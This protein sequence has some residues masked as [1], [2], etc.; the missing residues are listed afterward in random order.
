MSLF[1]DSILPVV[2]VIIL[3]TIGLIFIFRFIPATKKETKVIPE[4]PAE[5]RTLENMWK[6]FNMQIVKLHELGKY[7]E[8]ALLA[9]EA[10]KMAKESLNP[11]HPQIPIL[12]NNVAALYK[13]QGKISEAESLYKQ[14][15]AIWAK[16]SGRE[17]SE[18]AFSLNNLAELYFSTGKYKEAEP[19][20]KQ[21][22]NMFEKLLGK[23]DISVAT[24]LDNIADLYKKTGRS[25]KAVILEERARLIRE[26]IKKKPK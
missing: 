7:A 23:N 16:I 24:V 3:V 12:M 22:L 10:L 2:I 4:L 17:N 13:T 8:A 11:D 14:A 1:F 25:D 18:F 6:S 15:L 9:E 19:M 26:R 21:S 20:Y 5:A